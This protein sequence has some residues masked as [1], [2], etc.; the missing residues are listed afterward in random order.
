MFA[1][2]RSLHVA[3][4]VAVLAAPAANAQDVQ[5]TTVTKVDMGG[6]MNA[7]MRMAGASEVKETAYIKGK[8]L[9]SDGDKQSTIFDLDNSRFISIN[10]AEKTYTSVPIA[11]FAQVATSSMRGVKAE[12]SKDQLKGTAV[13]SA[14]NKADFIVDLKVDPTK[15]RRNINGND[16][17]QVL[18]TMETNVHVTPQGQSQ[19]EEAGTLVILMDTW[20]ANSGPAA[21][22]VRAWEKAASKEIA[23]AAL[24]RRSNMGP[25]FSANPG[26]AEAMKKAQE[27]A[28]KVEGIAVLTTTHLVIVAPGKKFDRDLALKGSGSGGGAAPEQKRGGLRGMIGKAIESSRQ[29][30]Q[31]QKPAQEATQGT[32][33]KVVT[34][35]RD[36]KST[37]LPAS[38]F[39][40]PAGYREVKVETTSR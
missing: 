38:L 31:E 4:L 22:V 11:D 40:I 24:S 23:A 34:E 6:G 30:Q 19:S 37:S 8:K 2:S 29:P 14:G 17:E 12:V 1:T 13:D 20:N 35:I 5:Y 33:A 27:E 28:Q 16:A 36:V 3:A 9:R 39:E 21:D 25:A 15:A 32:L 10:H 18:V 26:M 7:I